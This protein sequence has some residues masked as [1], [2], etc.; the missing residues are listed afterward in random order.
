MLVENYIDFMVWHCVHV[1]C[2]RCSAEASGAQDASLHLD[3]T[4]RLPAAIPGEVWE[5]VAAADQCGL[6][7]HSKT[8][9]PWQTGSLFSTYKQKPDT[10]IEGDITRF[11]KERK[12]FL[13]T[14]MTNQWSFCNISFRSI[15]L[16]QFST[17]RAFVLLMHLNIDVQMSSFARTG[18]HCFY[19]F[20]SDFYCELT[21]C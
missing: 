2:R 9:P 16:I 20:M 19:R 13:S 18:K 8:R 14:A 15:F 17:V 6:P 10:V 7:Q 21:I 3:E 11:H 5:P 4:D 1:V 12:Y